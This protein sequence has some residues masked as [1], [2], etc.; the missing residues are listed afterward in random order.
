MVKWNLEMR[1]LDNAASSGSV[2]QKQEALSR[3][4]SLSA[5]MPEAI[6]EQLLDRA[7]LLEAQLS[8]M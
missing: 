8:R 6:A 2:E 3:F 1:E 5:A 4:W 7:E